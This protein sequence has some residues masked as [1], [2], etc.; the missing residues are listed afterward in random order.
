MTVLSQ[1]LH[2]VWFP[3]NPIGWLWKIIA[4]NNDHA[5][6][7]RY[8]YTRLPM[9]TCSVLEVFQKAATQ[10]LE[11][12][13]GCAVMH[14]DIAVRGITIEE[15]DHQ[16]EA[17]CERMQSAGLSFN[18]D[19][20]IHIPT[21]TGD[22]LNIKMSSYQYRAPHVFKRYKQRVLMHGH[23]GWNVRHG[24]CHI[25]MRYVYIYIYELF[26]AFVSFVVCSLL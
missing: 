10:H 5:L 8:R 23:Q 3:S 22:S 16:L 26:I 21:D 18:I 19:K 25:Y 4:C 24:L 13:D 7:G 15:H 12:L 14:D 11:D 9:G 17:V 20:F 1:I 6:F 2:L